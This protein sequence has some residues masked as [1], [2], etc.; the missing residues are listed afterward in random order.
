M[1][2]RNKW[3][4]AVDLYFILKNKNYLLENLFKLSKKYFV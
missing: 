1:M 4:D 3:K 2:T